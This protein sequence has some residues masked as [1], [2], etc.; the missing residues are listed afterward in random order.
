MLLFKTVRKR[1]KNPEEIWKGCEDKQTIR[2][3]RTHSVGK[4]QNNPNPTW[5]R[6]GWEGV[7]KG[8]P[9]E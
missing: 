5:R 7:N 1:E 9:R 8:S 4:D 3:K 2:P 6:I